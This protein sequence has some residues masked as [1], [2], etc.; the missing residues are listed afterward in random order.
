MQIE[1]RMIERQGQAITSF[2][3]SLPAPLSDL[4]RESL[5]DP[6]RLD[7]LGL[8]AEAQERAIES[9]LVEQV[10]EFLLE[11]GAGDSGGFLSQPMK[12]L[13][14]VVLRKA[15]EDHTE[16]ENAVRDSGLPWTIVRPGG[17]RNSPATGQIAALEA[18]GR[19]TATIARADVA[20]FI[21]DC[22][23]NPET[24]GHTYALGT[25]S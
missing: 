6:Y 11:L 15:L 19:F 18:P 5:K 4:A 7:F 1:T 17:L 8:G 14:S 25:P 3:S 10:T 16:Q 20:A 24:A 2:E 21:L 23:E 22:I 12:L 9:A 13:T